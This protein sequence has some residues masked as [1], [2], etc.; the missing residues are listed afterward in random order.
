M[1][2]PVFNQDP[3][4]EDLHNYIDDGDNPIG[5]EISLD[6]GDPGE[7]LAVIRIENDG[8][9]TAVWPNR[10]EFH[11][12]HNPIDFPA[13][14]RL[15]SFFNEYGEF[16]TIPAK[17]A[18]VPFRLFLKAQPADDD[19]NAGVPMFEIMDNR[20]DRNRLFAIHNDGSIE[21]QF[22]GQKV[23][24]VPT[25]TSGWASEPDGTLWIEYTP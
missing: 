2:Y 21:S 17:G 9:D 16:R 14:T 4:I 15:T 12:V 6:A 5:Q 1:P 10:V 11:Y 18:T 3:W 23:R 7:R 24:T 20:G 19:H 13:V 25:G 22:V 8:T